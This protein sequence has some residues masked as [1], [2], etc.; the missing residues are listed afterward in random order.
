MIL[1]GTYVLASSLQVSSLDAPQN[2]CA[3]FWSS[4]SVWVSRCGPRSVVEGNWGETAGAAIPHTASPSP[5]FTAGK[6][7]A[8][9]GDVTCSGS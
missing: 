3:V 1:M 8:Q 5:H 6:T 7:E 2:H 9:K 4:H